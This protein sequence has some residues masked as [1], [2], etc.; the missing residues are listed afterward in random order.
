MGF[1]HPSNV[2]VNGINCRGRQILDGGCNLAVNSIQ[3]N[4]LV[5]SGISETIGPTLQISSGYTELNGDLVLNGEFDYETANASV[6]DALVWNG[7]KWS[8]GVTAGAFEIVSLV[9]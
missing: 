3:S 7:T 4:S 6:G 5:L 9:I 2:F 1:G 8:P